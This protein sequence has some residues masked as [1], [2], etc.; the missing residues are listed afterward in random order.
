MIAYF[1]NILGSPK[2][3]S[4]ACILL[5]GHP[6]DCGE[7]AG[8]LGG[9]LGG[10]F[11]ESFPDVQ[12]GV[13]CPSLSTDLVSTEFPLPNPFLLKIEWFPVLATKPNLV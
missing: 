12:P 11:Q 6:L 5:A 3:F 10:V 9:Q 1:K 8:L 2:C 7:A 13:H 4:L